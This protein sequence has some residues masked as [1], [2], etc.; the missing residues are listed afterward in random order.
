[1]KTGLK[2]PTRRAKALCKEIMV[3]Y[4]CYGLLPMEE[5]GL[6]CNDRS[7]VGKVN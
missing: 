2:P 5:I 3:S 1:M 7:D 4:K 6:I